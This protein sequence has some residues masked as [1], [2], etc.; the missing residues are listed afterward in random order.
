MK[1][2]FDGAVE[3]G[4]LEEEKIY[5]WPR[6]CVFLEF[7]SPREMSFLCL[8]VERNLFS[9]RKIYLSFLFFFFLVS[10]SRSSLMLGQ[11]YYALLGEQAFHAPGAENETPFTYSIP[12][13]PRF[14]VGVY[15]LQESG[16]KR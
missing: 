1:S 7:P 10:D 5:P 12:A 11:I 4:G 9:Y 15:P 13:S 14:D 16:T 2:V 6:P 8:F 3:Q